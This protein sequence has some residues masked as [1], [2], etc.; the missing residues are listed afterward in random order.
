MK[1][2]G[3]CIKCVDGQCQLFKVALS[4]SKTNDWLQD[5]NCRG[6]F[7]EN[8]HS[9]SLSKTLR[10]DKPKKIKKSQLQDVADDVF[11]TYVRMRDNYKCCTCGS[12]FEWGERA[13]LHG[14]HFYSR[15]EKPIRYDEQNCHAQ[16][17][18]CNAAMNW[19]D[20]KVK[21]RYNLFMLNK[22]GKETLERLDNE[23]RK[24]IKANELFYLE[25]IEKYSKLNDAIDEKWQ[26]FLNPT[27]K[28][29]LN[30]INN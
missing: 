1:L 8:K 5:L 26:E 30:K 24:S 13:L 16:C 6:R 10:K 11:Q 7:L 15:G 12:Q 17:K 23:M 28:R 2:C 29:L 20:G 22:Y 4:K 25:V 27:N 18:N 9:L 19:T 14:G 3:K 21:S